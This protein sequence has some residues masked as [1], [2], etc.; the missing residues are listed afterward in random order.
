M[1]MNYKDNFEMLQKQHKALEEKHK[2][3]RACIAGMAQQLRELEG[4]YDEELDCSTS[5][6]QVPSFGIHIQL[7]QALMGA[8]PPEPEEQARESRKKK[9]K[10]LG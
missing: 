2:N 9:F 5:W 10:V 1:P 8:V 3:L 7:L 4:P 6:P